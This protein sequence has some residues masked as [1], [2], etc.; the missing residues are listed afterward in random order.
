M[1]RQS[2]KNRQVPQ[3]HQAPQARHAHQTGQVPVAPYFPFF[4]ALRGYGGRVPYFPYLLP[5]FP[6]SGLIQFYSTPQGVRYKHWPPQNQ[7][8]H[9]AESGCATLMEHAAWQRTVRQAAQHCCVLSC[10][11]HSFGVWPVHLG[12]TD[13]WS[14]QAMRM[15]RR[16]P[17]SMFLCSNALKSIS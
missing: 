12:H 14:T 11:F 16:R 17:L 7:Q 13:T 2:Y 8:C 6:P 5:Y 4:S 1:C 3:P 9:Y 10:S 15:L